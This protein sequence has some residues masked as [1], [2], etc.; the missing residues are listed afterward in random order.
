MNPNAYSRDERHHSTQPTRE[1]IPS[2]RPR[3]TGAET[4]PSKRHD[5]P[6]G[7]PSKPPTS[8]IPPV[9]AG[10]SANIK[11]GI[12]P[13]P[14]PSGDATSVQRTTTS[15]RSRYSLRR[16]PAP[17]GVQSPST[18]LPGSWIPTP[19]RRPTS[20]TT[21]LLRRSGALRPTES[22]G[23]RQ[24]TGKLIGTSLQSELVVKDQTL[25]QL[26]PL[27]P[28]TAGSHEPATSPSSSP[29]TGPRGSDSSTRDQTRPSLHDLG[30]PDPTT[31]PRKSRRRSPSSE[32]RFN[33]RGKKGLELHHQDIE[34]TGR[35]SPIRSPSM[36]ARRTSLVTMGT[37]PV[38]ILS[39]DRR[40]GSRNYSK[41]LPSKNE[42]SIPTEECSRTRSPS[43][44]NQQGLQ[45]EKQR[46]DVSQEQSQQC[47]CGQDARTR[48]PEPSRSNERLAR[49]V[50]NEVKVRVHGAVQDIMNIFADDFYNIINTLKDR[51]NPLSDLHNGLET[52]FANFELDIVG[53]NENLSSFESNISSLLSD[54]KQVIHEKENVFSHPCCYNDKLNKNLSSPSFLHDKGKTH[55]EMNMSCDCDVKLARIPSPRLK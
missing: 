35:T 15:A 42:R 14:G 52:M 23:P 49:I 10:W 8:L 54:V 41:R 16:T 31:S 32:L 50:A 40:T 28:S 46:N 17:R 53:F 33:D 39:Q 9:P 12:G 24:L 51:I 22:S 25:A 4:G 27:P 34:R 7:G 26:T 43:V 19:G 3:A 37:Q 36:D 11:T 29:S 20:A 13:E 5:Q 55:V 38:R 21:S 47:H 30:K 1:P 45:K 18:V 44:I 6:Y 48:S 2:R